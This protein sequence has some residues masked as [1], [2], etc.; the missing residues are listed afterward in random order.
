MK[1]FLL[2][3]LFF[4]GVVSVG[5]G[6]SAG[7]FQ[8]RQSGNWNDSNTWEEWTGS[9][10]D[11]TANTPT[12]ADGNITIIDSHSITIVSSLTIDQTVIQSNASLSVDP[13]NTLTIADGS[14]TDLTIQSSGSLTLNDDFFFD[15]SILN[16]NGNVINSGSLTLSDP[17][18]STINFNANSAYQHAQNNGAIPIANWATSSTTIISGVTNAVPTNINQSYGNFTWNCPSQ[19]STLFL[20]LTG[21]NTTVAGNFTVSSTGGRTLALSS[22]SGVVFEVGNIILSGSTRLAL[23]S[24]GNVT[25]NTVNFSNTST[26]VFLGTSG[27][28]ILNVSGNYSHNSGTIQGTGTSRITFAGS[29]EQ[30]YNASGGAY[31]NVN[32]RLNSSAI[33]NS[34][35]SNFSGTGSFNMNPGSQLILAEPNGISLGTTSG[36]IRVSGTRTYGSGITLSF[37]GSTLQNLGD[38]FPSTD[39]NLTVNNTGA[40]VNMSSDIM[41]SSGRTLNLTEGTLNIGDGNLLTLNGNVVTT[42]GGISGGSLSDLTIGGT[43]AFGT[44]GFV[45]TQELRNFTINRTSSGT[46]T[47]GGDLLI[48]GTFEQTAGNLILNGNTFTL[49]GPYSRT[50]GSLVSDAAASLIINGSGALPSPASFSGDI[51]TLTLDR[52]SSTFNVGGSGFTA[53]NIN[54]FSGEL[55]GSAISIADGGNVERQSSGVLTNEL[56]A[57][58]TYNLLYNNDVTFNSGAELSTDPTAIANLEKAGTGDLDIQNDFTVNGTLTFTNGIFNAGTNTISLNGDLVSGAGSNL[59]SATIT[60]DG[61][62]NLTGGTVPTFGDITVNA[63]FNPATSLNVNGNI[64]NNGTLNSSAGTLTIN[65]TSQLGGT[66]PITVNNLTIG[67][68]GA[69]TANSSQALTING[70]IDNSG[71]FNANGGTVIFGGTTSISGTVPTFANIQVDGTFNAP[72]TLNI[73]GGLTNNGTFNDNDGIINMNGS[74]TREISG[75]SAF[76]IYTLNVSG[77]TVNNNNTGVVFIEDGITVGASTTLDLD[78]GGTGIM[79]LLST[80]TKDAFIG[81]IPSGSAVSG[82]VTVQR[83]LYA[84]DAGD[85]A[86]HIVGFPMSNVAVSDIQNE[87]PVTGVFSGSST[88]TGYDNNPSMYAYDEDA[89]AGLTLNERYVAFPSSSNTET[90]NVGEGYYLYTY[91]GVIPVTM[92]GTGLINT[93]SFTRSLSFTGTD[94][95]AGWHLVANPYPAP[96]DWSQWGKTAI[97][98]NTAQIYNSNTGAYIAYDG[99][100]EQLIPQ[101]QGFFVQATDGTGELTATESTKV[102]STT[103]TYF[104][105]TDIPQRFE[106][107]LTTP[108]YDD[109]AIV[110][111][112]DGATDA[113]EAA[114][115]ANRLLNTYETISTLSSDGKPLK[116]NRMASISSASPCSRSINISFE[117]LKNEVTYSITF[118]D[119]GKVPSQSFQ[120]VDHYLDKN[121][122]VD[123]KTKYNFTVN[124]DGESKSSDRFELLISSNSPSQISTSSSDVCPNQNAELILENTDS[125]VTYLL[126]KDSELLTSVEGTGATL[127][128]DVSKEV[129]VDEI[130]DFVLKGFVAGCDTVSVGSVQIKIAEALSLDNK[131]TGSSICKI[132]TQAPFSI[133]TQLDANYYLVQNE[134]TIQSIQGTGSQYDGYIAAENLNDG[135]NEFVITADKDGCQSGTLE[136]VLEIVVENLSIDRTVTFETSDICN[137]NEASINFKSQANVEYKFYKNDEVVNTLIGDGSNQSFTIPSEFVEVGNNEYYVMAY[138]GSCSEYEFAEKIS[139]TVEESIQSNLDIVT[140]NVCGLQNVNVIIENAQKAKKYSLVRDGEIAHSA[141][142][143]TDGQLSFTLDSSK[144]KMGINQ[145]NIL[146]EGEYCQ[147]INAEQIVEFALYEDAVIESIENQN[148]CLNGRATIEM[149]ANV[150]ID[151]YLVYIGN[152]LISETQ[153]NIINLEPKES[154]TYRLTGVPANG[155]KI[156]DIN[157]TIEVTDLTVPG[158]LVSGNVLESSIE[159]DSYQW[160]LDGNQMD[161]ET[162]KVLVANASG[163]Y[164]VEVS[165]GDCSKISESFTFNEEVLNANKALENALKLYPNPVIDKMFIDLNN[166]NSVDITIFTITGKFIDSFVLNAGHSEIDMAKFSKGTYLIQIESD[167]GVVTKRIVKQ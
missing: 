87:L 123:N 33:I 152:E 10:W 64:T 96:T 98:G 132:E 82:T 57:V 15:G 30:L 145:Y 151:K 19:S 28:G 166:I 115:D 163:D 20:G 2:S 114:F 73:S 39:V 102:T 27:S 117:Q 130:N 142:A 40:G 101:G 136:Q 116:V 131:V 36:V 71:S 70:D 24:S 3:I 108:D 137:S 63:T 69:V 86:Y 129:L 156:N 54:L 135:L 158:I 99:S 105:E 7:D 120:L 122:S 167:N 111:F 143:N 128:L 72:A 34:G 107:V 77:G 83:A 16:I 67:G 75:S 55:T 49:S 46:V 62:T 164:K 92:D 121:I 68:S 8:T 140:E 125:Y 78:G 124:S 25:V 155:C 118:N 65:A 17:N 154:T 157:F 104:R 94:P 110:H 95:D 90:F 47:L 162:G 165:K 153:S 53:S 11:N 42:S 45:G 161:S 44:L 23:T 126:Y 127:D 38:G 97:A 58:G 48:N 4:V 32:F 85:N 52:A 59:T 18:L 31:T 13:F 22:A 134:D 12:S 109:V 133:A 56:T 79:T 43:G 6:Q 149:S 159:G 138:L 150:E 37:N 84:T 139:L 60:F 160:Y 103:P 88:G 146:I 76:N 119:L 1:R 147:S 141:T 106:I 51:N 74:G 81:E 66:N 113:Y 26:F 14:G 144:L 41:I 89:G 91:P 29:T 21:S 112:A 9:S 148:I 5:V 80:S 93:G 35:T 61:T 50:A 100:S